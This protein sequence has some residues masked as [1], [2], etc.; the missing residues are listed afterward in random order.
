MALPWL[1]IQL[2]TA[3]SWPKLVALEVTAIRDTSIAN[4]RIGLADLFA[5]GS[6]VR[7]PT[8]ELRTPS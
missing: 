8:S 4:R 3:Y 1:P 5:S 6:V 7:R 2:G